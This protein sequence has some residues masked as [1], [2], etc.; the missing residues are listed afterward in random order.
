MKW[1]YLLIFLILLKCIKIIGIGDWRGLMLYNLTYLY[2][3]VYLLDAMFDY[4]DSKYLLD[5]ETKIDEYCLKFNKPSEF[6]LIQ[7]ECSYSC[8]ETT[9]KRY[10]EKNRREARNTIGPKHYPMGGIIS[11]IFVKTYKDFFM[12]LIEGCYAITENGSKYYGN[13]T[14]IPRNEKNYANYISRF[15]PDKWKEVKFQLY[16]ETCDTICKNLM[17]CI[18]NKPTLKKGTSS[19]FYCSFVI[20]CL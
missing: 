8:S 13:F 17:T 16:T 9:I 4:E 14:L 11:R 5:E 2:D 19:I 7:Y 1:L 15:S 18:G 20:C 12:I 6:T 10:I 3:P